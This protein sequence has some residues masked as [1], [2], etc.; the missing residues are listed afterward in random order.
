MFC[1]AIRKAGTFLRRP[2][3]VILWVPPLWLALG[4]AKVVI[5]TIPFR[6]LA[7]YLGH[8]SGVNPFVPLVPDEL[9]QR[10]FLIGQAVTLAARHTPWSSNCF[11]QALVARFLL[12]F[13]RIPCALY[14]GVKRHPLSGQVEAHAWVAAGRVCVT[15]GDGFDQFT[16]VGIF[17]VPEIKSRLL[18]SQFSAA[19]KAGS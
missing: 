1:N 4:A 16:V 9:E 10:A 7:I 18:S 17:A 12:R 3:F 14:F 15:G 2:V 6:R 11:P 8:R 13:Y 19:A 5:F